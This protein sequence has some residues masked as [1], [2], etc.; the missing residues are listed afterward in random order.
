MKPFRLVCRAGALFFALMA[1]ITV[2]AV[3]RGYRQLTE[4]ELSF[5][6]RVEQDSYA[7]PRSALC[8]DEQGRSWVFLVLEQEGPW[9]KEYVCKQVYLPFGELDQGQVIVSE[10]LLS[11]YPIAIGGKAELTDG[12]RVRF[13]E[14]RG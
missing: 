6:Q 10:N 5:A 12:Q 4:V 2:Y 9:G 14:G 8:T 1:G 13:G 11:Q 3:S 7:V